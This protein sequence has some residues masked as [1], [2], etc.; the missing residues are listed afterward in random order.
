MS[1]VNLFLGVVLLLI[2][3]VTSILF[4]GIFIPAEPA[5]ELS[6]AQWGCGTSSLYSITAGNDSINYNI[7]KNVFANLCASCH[8]KN[9]ID[10][11]TGP[12]LSGSISRFGNDTSRYFE[13][14]KSPHLYLLK[15]LDARVVSLHK[16][17]GE[18]E[19]P[20]FEGLTQNELKSILL[21]VD[22]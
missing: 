3:V 12:A 21:Y 6:D 1:N 19:K 2:A 18:V 9:M 8:N 16:E 14:V 15:E 11:L 4:Y 7:G 22:R 17:F 13:Y 20:G 10:D 5:D